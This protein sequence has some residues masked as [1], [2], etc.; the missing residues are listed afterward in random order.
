M[1]ELKIERV[2]KVFA[3][4]R[5]Q[6]IDPL[7]V[8]RFGFD[9]K[10]IPE[11][12]YEALVKANASHPNFRRGN[13]HAWNIVKQD[14]GKDGMEIEYYNVVKMKNGDVIPLDPVVKLEQIHDSRD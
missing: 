6:G 12:E 11:E 2:L 1:T 5:K 9:P 4:I 8:V 10:V 7:E 13:P 3:E 14:T